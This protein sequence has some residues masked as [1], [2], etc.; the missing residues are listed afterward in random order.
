MVLDGF[1]FDADRRLWC[2]LA[3]GLGVPELCEDEAHLLS[4][5]AAKEVILSVGRSAH[6]DFSLNPLSGVAGSFFTD[7]RLRDLRDLVEFM[8]ASG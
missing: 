8:I 6:G 7:H 3:I 4:N 5:R 1:N 2:P